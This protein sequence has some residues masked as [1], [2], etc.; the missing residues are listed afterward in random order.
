MT[1]KHGS[2]VNSQTPT[3]EKPIDLISGLQVAIGTAPIHLAEDSNSTNQPVVAYTL[4]EAQA[5]LGYSDDWDSYTLCE[6]MDTSFNLYGVAPVIFINVLNAEKHVSNENETSSIVDG[7]CTLEKSGVLTD[8]I[9]VKLEVLGEELTLDED[10]AIT[11]QSDGIVLITVLP[12]SIIPE[13][14]ETLYITYDVIDSALVTEEDIIGGLDVDTGVATG[15]E[16]LAQLFPK[17]GLVPGTVIA[18]G[19]S[20]NPLIESVM[21]VKSE[22]INSLFGA[23]CVCDVDAET[24]NHYSKVEDWKNEN[25]YTGTNELVTWPQ[26]G[27]RKKKYRL[28]SHVAALMALT[29]SNNEGIPSQSPSNQRIKI[30]KVTLADAREVYLAPDDSNSLNG[31]GVF[32]TLMWG[33]GFKGWGNRLGNYNS[34]YQSTEPSDQFISMKR[35]RQWLSNQII[36]KTWERVDGPISTRLATSICDELNVWMN[37]LVSSYH[38]IGGRVEFRKSDNPAEQ[39]ENGHMVFRVYVAESAPGELLEFIVEF[40]STYYENLF[41]EE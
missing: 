32:T 8:S 38:L 26:V 3:V 14:Q 36:L 37:G 28:S 19:F 41:S 24:V 7:I 18:P 21:K 12:D 1:Y 30:D 29:D 22:L 20:D 23:M 9:K 10:Y 34:E 13:D 16:L 4:E 39:L 27:Y 6:V 17:S 35:M 15:L 5:A 40:D 25:D 33:G 11:V 31:I 2:Y